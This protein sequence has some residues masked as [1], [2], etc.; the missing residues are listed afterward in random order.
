L[1]FT[2]PTR[3]QSDKRALRAKRMGRK[4]AF[5]RSEMVALTLAA[6]VSQDFFEAL[7]HGRWR[8][9]CTAIQTT[10]EYCQAGSANEQ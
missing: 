2:P 7:G 6:V 5:Q 1:N 4:N 8:S 3:L 9:P 10:D